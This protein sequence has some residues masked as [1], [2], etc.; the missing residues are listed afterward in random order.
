MYFNGCA[1]T[2]HL[3]LHSKI[4]FNAYCFKCLMESYN[5]KHYQPVV[6]V[7]FT[8]PVQLLYSFKLNKQEACKR[9]SHTL[10][11]ANSCMKSSILI[12]QHTATLRAAG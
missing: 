11:A 4:A 2:S 10:S 12:L 3:I 8:I 6:F 5:L 7:V 9:L 1:L